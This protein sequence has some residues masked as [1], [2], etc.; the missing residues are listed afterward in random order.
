VS[1]LNIH[2]TGLLLDGTGVL[3]RGPSGSGKSLLALLLLEAFALQGKPALLV[4]DDRIDIITSDDCLEMQ[5]PPRLAG[6]IELRGRGI[7]SRP[8]V[9]RGPLHLVIDLVED[10]VRMQEDDAFRTELAGVSLDRAPVPRA[11]LVEVAHQRLL[12]EA[13]IAALQGRNHPQRQKTT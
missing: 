6:L 9:D 2:G 7:I 10:L 1:R 3:L 4:A 13:A 5:A 12:V 8:F 11:G